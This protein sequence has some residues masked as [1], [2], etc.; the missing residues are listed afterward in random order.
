[1]SELDAGPV[2]DETPAVEAAPEVEAVQ[3]DYEPA[4]EPG[5]DEPLDPEIEAQV[6]AIPDGDKM[7][8]LS[9]LTALRAKMKGTKSEAARAAELEAE[10]AQTRAHYAGQEP[11][12]QAAQALLAAKQA[13]NAAAQAAQAPPVDP[14]YV[15]ELRAVARDLDLYTPDGNPDLVRA[16]RIQ[17]RQAAQAQQMA[18]AATQPMIHQQ[19]VSAAMRMLEVAKQTKL[20]NSEERADPDLLDQLWQRVAAQPGGLEMLATP[21]QAIHVWN[22]AY[23]ATRARQALSP[24]AAA[25]VTAAQVG[26][27]MFSEKSGGGGGRPMAL[28]AMEA[29]AAKDMGMSEAEYLKAASKRPY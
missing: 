5:P 24:K 18:A 16:H 9:A 25:P 23:T 4:P 12:I 3:P 28:S 29:K 8:P 13:Q 22:Q 17:S 10:L 26:A 1:M 27:P 14:A 15:E 7:V 2:A 19:K 20:P 21:E 11:V 6:V